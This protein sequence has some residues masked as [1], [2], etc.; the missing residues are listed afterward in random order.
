MRSIELD[1]D[2]AECVAYAD[3]VQETECGKRRRGD[4][5]LVLGEGLPVLGERSARHRLAA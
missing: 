5:L 4:R 1:L 3:G 2:G